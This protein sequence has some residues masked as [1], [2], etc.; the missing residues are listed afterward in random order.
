MK[1]TLIATSA[2]LAIALAA[3]SGSST[4][5]TAPSNKGPCAGIED[6]A[7]RQACREER[8]GDPEAV[9]RPDAVADGEVTTETEVVL[10]GEAEVA[11]E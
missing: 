2:I 3:C 10:E 1:K 4:A 6:P 9:L 5:P 7:E 11:P 8:F